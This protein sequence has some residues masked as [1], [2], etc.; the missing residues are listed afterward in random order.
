MHSFTRLKVGEN[1]GDDTDAAPL[2]AL[3]SI[4][5]FKTKQQQQQKVAN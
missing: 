3:T 1:K 5:N 2:H 4:D